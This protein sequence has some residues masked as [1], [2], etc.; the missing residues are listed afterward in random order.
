MSYEHE[1]YSYAW[2]QKQALKR[3]VQLENCPIPVKTKEVRLHVASP[4]APKESKIRNIFCVVCGKQMAVRCRRQYACSPACKDIFTRRTKEIREKYSPFFARYCNECGS[5][6]LP[7]NKLMQFSR[8]HL[9]GVIKGVEVCVQGQAGK[10]LPDTK[11]N[12]KIGSNM[13]KKKRSGLQSCHGLGKI[14]VH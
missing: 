12:R 5:S 9:C 1:K 3:G 7:S 13:S 2:Y 6:F 10:L 11:E 14:E 4:V 8:Q